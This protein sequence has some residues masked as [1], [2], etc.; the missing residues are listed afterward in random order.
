MNWFTVCTAAALLAS[1]TSPGTSHAEGRWAPGFGSYIA[2]VT[3][4]DVTE[5][6]GQLWATRGFY[7]DVRSNDENLHVW[8]GSEWTRMQGPFDGLDDQ[9]AQP[10]RQVTH[11]DV[12]DG[13]LVAVAHS[14]DWGSGFPRLLLN[15]VATW[16]GEFWAPL[17]QGFRGQVQELFV[18]AGQVFAWVRYATNAHRLVAWNGLEWS[19]VTESED[20]WLGSFYS[21]GSDLLAA[22]SLSNATGSSLHGI[23]SWDGNSWR[24]IAPL[25]P[26]PVRCLHRFEG[27]L[28][29]GSEG[30]HSGDQ[31]IYR[32]DGLTWAPLGGGIPG[33]PDQI[34]FRAPRQ[35]GAGPATNLP[36]DPEK[37]P[38]CGH[39]P[40]HRDDSRR[41]SARRPPSS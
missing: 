33:P 39:R 1:F 8:D 19:A 22:G 12:F 7:T 17:G 9:F 26:G 10:W 23:F 28:I 38:C 25:P 31:M 32:F 41:A 6:N 37:D 18:H 11:V 4:R 13:K 40:R 14:E 34:A 29:A 20:D 16:D 30:R 27:D 3:P 36:L 24:E 15:R 5:W 35:C 2:T 21:D